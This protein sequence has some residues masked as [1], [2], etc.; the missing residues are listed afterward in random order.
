MQ[1]D[2]TTVTPVVYYNLFWWT[3]LILV[4]VSLYTWMLHSEA[5]WDKESKN[6]FP[7]DEKKTPPRPYNKRPMK[8]TKSSKFV[9]STGRQQDIVEPSEEVNL[10]M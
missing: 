4:L 1:C 10:R 7:G 8:V 3:L 9:D 6:W 5:K 2:P